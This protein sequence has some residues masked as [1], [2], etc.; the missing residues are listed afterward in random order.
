MQGRADT[1]AKEMKHRTPRRER[2][3]CRLIGAILVGGAS[4]RMGRDKTQMRLGARAVVPY[5]AEQLAVRCQEVWAIGRA[6]PQGD[7]PRFLR[8]RPDL[9]PGCGPLGGI[10]TA[11]RLAGTE[12]SAARA[13]SKKRPGSAKAAL[14]LACDMPMV[15]GELLDRLLEARDPDRPASIFRNPL[16]G[17]LEPMPG[18][19]EPTALQAIEQAM[20]TG[21]LAVTKLLEAVGA[22]VVEVPEDMGDQLLNVNTPEDLHAARMKA[23]E[24]H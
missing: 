5:L 23:C 2:L 18:I 22:H 1:S 17:R 8:S 9:H 16:T 3:G 20:A 4:R 12:P 10:A 21:R 24:K 11:L 15:R 14:V 13:K 7:W 6:W 19:Y